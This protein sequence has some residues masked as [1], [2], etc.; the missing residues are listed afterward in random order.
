[1]STEIVYPL[2]S[3]TTGK[4]VSGIEIVIVSYDETPVEYEIRARKGASTIVLCPYK[5]RLVQK[6]LEG[7]EVAFALEA[8]NED[9]QIVA[10]GK[11]A[12]G[13]PFIEL[14]CPYKCRIYELLT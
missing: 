9:Y 8:N 7:A 3:G 4:D 2:D 12:S 14:I 5:C 13:N 10:K 1:M 11:D 6:I